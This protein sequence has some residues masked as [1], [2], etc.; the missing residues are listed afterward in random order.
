VA[1][2]PPQ[3]QTVT[4]TQNA[5]GTVQETNVAVVKGKPVSETPEEPVEM[6]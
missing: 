2:H 1:E 5:D 4:Y 3:E 6:K